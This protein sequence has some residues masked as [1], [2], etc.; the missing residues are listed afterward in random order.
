MASWRAD[1]V[2]LL[3]LS[4]FN[5]ESLVESVWATTANTQDSRLMESRHLTKELAHGVFY[6]NKHTMEEKQGGGNAVERGMKE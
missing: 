4:S 1:F 2:L 6:K 5:S 3:L